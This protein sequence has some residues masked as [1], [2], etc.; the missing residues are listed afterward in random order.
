MVAALGFFVAW[1]T[2]RVAVKGDPRTPLFHCARPGRC[3]RLGLLRRACELDCRSQGRP[4]NPPRRRPPNPPFPLRSAWPRRSVW[5]CLACVR[6]GL[7]QSGEALNPLFRCGRPG[8]CAWLLWRANKG[9]VHVL[10]GNF[11]R[12]PVKGVGD[13]KAREL[14]HNASARDAPKVWVFR[15]FGCNVPLPIQSA[16]PRS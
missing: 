14:G 6:V 8:R 15:G 12:W 16:S 3:A 2:C 5:P 7:S 13:A 4:P 1:A 11:T 10:C 9:R